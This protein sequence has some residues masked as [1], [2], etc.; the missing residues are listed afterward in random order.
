V[1]LQK[2][3]KSKNKEQDY[4]NLPVEFWGKEIRLTVATKLTLVRMALTPF[5]CVS[6]FYMKIHYALALF[7][8]A[9]VSDSLD[10]FV[11]RLF[12]QETPL[13][14][15]LDPLADKVLLNS[16]NLILSFGSIFSLITIP[17]WLTLVILCRDILII[18]C[19]SLIIIIANY[20]DIYPS[21][22]G[23]LSTIFQFI[24]I[25]TVLFA[26]LYQIAND[27]FQILF[28][29]TL[30]FTV[31]SGVLYLILIGKLINKIYSSQ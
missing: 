21:W 25:I 22:S 16:V 6:I 2:D 13:G 20:K 23:K 3:T 27:Y 10:G 24:S 17:V 11:A 26:N 9:A 18:A 8:I 19:V 5:I 14:R 4:I 7:I 31:Y 1:T 15:M 12:K 28:Y 30:F 29:I